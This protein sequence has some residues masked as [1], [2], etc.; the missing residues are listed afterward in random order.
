MSLHIIIDGYNLIRQSERFSSRGTADLQQERE[1]LVEALCAYKKVRRHKI[2]LIFDGAQSPPFAK[3][4]DH[5]KGINIRYSRRGETADAVIQKMAAHDKEKA[6]VV[7]S[8]REIITFAE[9]QGAA[10]I[11]SVQFEVKLILAE[12]TDAKPAEPEESPNR[13]LSTRKKGPRKRLSK[14]KRRNRVKTRKL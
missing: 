12:M 14:R 4:R 9:S 8:D 5:V 13:N 11:D 10:T 3:A 6:I 7:S 1:A 2:S